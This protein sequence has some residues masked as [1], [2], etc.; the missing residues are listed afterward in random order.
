MISEQY[1]PV[2]CFVIY[3]HM[4]AKR[5]RANRISRYA[6]VCSVHFVSEV[7]LSSKNTQVRHAIMPKRLIF[8]V[9]KYCIT[10]ACMRPVITK[11]TCTYKIHLFITKNTYKSMYVPCHFQTRMSLGPWVEHTDASLLDQVIASKACARCC[12]HRDSFSADIS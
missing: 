3:Q 1:I 11:N 8:Q 12:Q 2:R 6:K 7:R 5:L 10:H 9:R 4:C